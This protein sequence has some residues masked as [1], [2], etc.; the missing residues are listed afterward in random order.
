MIHVHRLTMLS[1]AQS[2]VIP[3]AGFPS[4]FSLANSS[5]SSNPS[6]LLGI[7]P[8]VWCD[9]VHPGPRLLVNWPPP[10]HSNFPSPQGIPS[11]IVCPTKT[12]SRSRLHIVR[13]MYPRLILWD[14]VNIRWY[15]TCTNRNTCT[16][17]IDI[18]TGKISKQ[19]ADSKD[20]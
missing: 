10:P 12:I 14:R 8:L 3:L 4:L 18:F 11:L 16:Y 20:W 1:Y 13:N 7:P 15:C 9:P 5:L 2:L 19:W 6:Y 17:W